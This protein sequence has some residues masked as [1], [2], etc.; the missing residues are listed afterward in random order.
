[1]TTLHENGLNDDSKVIGVVNEELNDVEPRVTPFEMGTNRE[2]WNDDNDEA[3]VAEFDLR[4]T[5][6]NLRKNFVNMTPDN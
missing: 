1:M 6:A 3:D 2:D 5:S 4:H